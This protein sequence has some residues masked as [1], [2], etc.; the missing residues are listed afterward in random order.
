MGPY[1]NP[2]TIESSSSA[3]LLQNSSPFLFPPSTF[4]PIQVSPQVNPKSPTRRRNMEPH[5]P[6]AGRPQRKPLGDCTNT[7]SRT[8]QLPS[9]PS[10]VKFANPSLSSS[11]K[12]LVDQTSLK[13]KAQVVNISSKAVPGTGNAP[14][15]VRPVTRRTSA[16]L[17]SP[18]ATT[19]SPPSK[20]DDVGKPDAGAASRLRPV[21]RRMSADLGFP[22]SAP[23]R[24]RSGIER[25]NLLIRVCLVTFLG[26]GDKDFTEPYSVYTVR[27][28][29]S[30]RKRSKD[31]SS[32]SAMPRLRLDLLSSPG[33]RKLPEDENKTKP[34]K[35]APKK[36]QRTVKKHKED[37][38]DQEYIEQQKAYFAEV[39]A[40]ELQEEEVSSS[41]LD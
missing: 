25:R 7:I 19:S 29:A 9:S 34:S 40:F 22:A 10:S 20:P 33:K 5:R 35:V 12:R 8:P 1:I 24:P 3:S 18:A 39:D 31:V 28:K 30:G 32:S 16:D 23:P 37:N 41:D 26:V 4:P 27:R 38:V 36:R 2:L 13:E 15:S 17:G 14:K 21:T 6:L 11:L